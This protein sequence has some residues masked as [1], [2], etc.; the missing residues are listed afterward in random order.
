MFAGVLASYLYLVYNANNTVWFCNIWSKREN[1]S[2]WR[3]TENL[4]AK[5]PAFGMFSG[6]NRVPVLLKEFTQ[7]A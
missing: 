4:L 7:A 5:M 6:L 3:V 2:P 1:I